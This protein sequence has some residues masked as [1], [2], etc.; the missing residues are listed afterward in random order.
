V[1]IV[2]VCVFIVC[3]CVCVWVRVTTRHPCPHPISCALRHRRL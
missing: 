1:F 3:V 2:C